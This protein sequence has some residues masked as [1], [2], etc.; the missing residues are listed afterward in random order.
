MYLPSNGVLQEVISSGKLDLFTNPE[1]RKLLSSWGGV[2]DKVRFQ[3]TELSKYRIQLTDM[4]DSVG[5]FRQTVHQ[6]YGNSLN[7]GTSKFDNDNLKLLQDRTFENNLTAFVFSSRFANKNY[8][9]NLEEKIED[10]LK[11]INTEIK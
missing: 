8:Y 2:L 3:E 4:W 6:N 9:S 11:I 5:N 10:I 1:L 7:I